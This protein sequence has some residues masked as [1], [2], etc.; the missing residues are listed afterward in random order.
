[1]DSTPHS[2]RQRFRDWR[3]A[4]P[5]DPATTSRP[6][7]RDW[8]AEQEPW[9]YR[10]AHRPVWVLL[11]SFFGLLGHHRGRIA[12]AVTMLIAATLLGLL[13]PLSTMIAFDYILTDSPGPAG[14]AW[15]GLGTD[16]ARLLWVLGGAMVVN[17]LLMAA[18]GTA[19]R[20]MMTRLN[21]LLQAELRRRLFAH[22]ARLPLHRLHAIKS[23]GVSSILREDAG[24]VGD[25]LFNVFYNPLRAVITLLGGLTALAIIDWR[26]LVGGLLLIPAVYYSHRTWV[27]RIRPVQRA[28]RQNRTAMDA[29]ATEAF[30]GIRVVRAYARATGESL[31]FV[32][33]NN[34]M[35]RQ[36]ILAWWWM[37]FVEVIWVVLIPLAS[38]GALVYGGLQVLSG[39]LTIGQVAAFIGYLMMLLGPLDVL[40]STS[41]AMQSGLAGFDRCLDVLAEKPEFAELQRPSGTLR[42]V[43][44]ETTLGDIELE[45]VSFAYPGHSQNVLQSIDLRVTAGTTVA[46]VGPSGS[47]KTTLCNLVARFFDPTRGRVMLDGVDLRDIDVDSYRRLLGIVEQDVFLFDGTIAEN[48]AYARRGA[49]PEQIRQAARSA[50]ADVFIEAMERGYDT[51]IGERGV[52]LSGGQKQRLAIAR[53]LLADPRILILDEATSNLDT[54][55]ERLIQASLARLMRGRTCF[56]IAHRLSTVRTADHIVVL[57]QGRIIETGT[58]DTLTASGGR[59]ARMLALQ[60]SP[61]PDL[62]LP[63]TLPTPHPATE[64]YP[65]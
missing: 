38:A 26:M 59:Y 60:L 53:A 43:S 1:M 49:T 55:S 36:E 22:M 10:R 39:S 29:H 13:M 50:N 40:V 20:A 62:E 28:I 11:R 58:H 54:E 33:N 65:R 64:G 37:R 41:T 45:S 44:R 27:G 12:L 35:A 23:G 19:G 5:A 31:H 7:P 57:D 52:R 9:G 63:P 47:G 34:L 30:A 3:H 16:R 56:V 51:V 17:A 2:S 42:S 15:L 21:K 46:L 14:L 18:A 32:R 25:M 8:T 24:V 6:A 48:I 4:L 61:P